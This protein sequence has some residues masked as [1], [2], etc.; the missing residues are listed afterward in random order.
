M[1]NELRHKD[2]GRQLTKDEWE[3]LGIH[4]AEGQTADDMLYFNGTSWVRATP[5]TINALMVK[6][7]SARFGYGVGGG[8][9]IS[10]Q[11]AY[12]CSELANGADGWLI[13]NVIPIPSE[14][15]S[16]VKAVL[17]FNSP[18]SG[19]VRIA[20]TSEYGANGE[21][22]DAATENMPEA[23]V[24]IVADTIYEYDISSILTGINANDYLGFT[25]FRDGDDGLDTLADGLYVYG[26]FIEYK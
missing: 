16:I 12:A 26:V 11:S 25:L 1:A 24:A 23:T 2:V 6:S 20:V 22:H 21:A 9:A 19:N 15:S 8:T 7:L 14:F 4:I 13:A 10:F 17:I 18:A 3:A 5:P